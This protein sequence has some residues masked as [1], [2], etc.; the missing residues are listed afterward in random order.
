MGLDPRYLRR[1]RWL[2]KARA[3][4]AVGAPT[5]SNL[6]YLLLDPEVANFTYEIGNNDELAAWVDFVCGCGFARAQQLIA[7]PLSDARLAT[8]LRTA[9]SAHRL[10]TKAA[11]QFGKRRAWY[12]L[13]RALEPELIIETG[14]HDG[15]GSLVL[16]RALER[17]AEDGHDGRLISIDIN[18]ACGWLVGTDRRW[19]LRIGATRDVLAE[20]VRHAPP[21]GMFVHDSLHSY[22]NQ[23]FELR[24]AAA[25]LA[26][27]GVL[28]SD[29]A[30]ITN[31]LLET[32]QEFSLHIGE[33]IERPIGHFYTGGH[34]AAGFRDTEPQS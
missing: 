9:T 11:P 17:N 27:A 24:T 5:R 31:A 14:V 21:V 4:R 13:A 19:D 26:P 30:H 34:M 33:F 3:V 16:L 2:S 32:C 28:I 7:E 18:P 20:V 6:R 23:R 22:E 29:D 10:W 12:A 1:L 25:H 15:L 8:R